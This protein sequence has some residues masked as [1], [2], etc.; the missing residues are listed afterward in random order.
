MK[1]TSIKNWL[2]LGMIFFAVMVCLVFSVDALARVG[3]GHS[4]GGG[5]S[6][7]GGRGGSSGDGGAIIWLIFQL[8]RFLVYL[9]IEYPLIGI[10]L[11]LIVVGGVVYFFA[12][13]KRTVST[14][15][16]S[17]AQAARVS[18]A[19]TSGRPEVIARSFNQLRKFDPNFSEIVFTDFCYA[20]Y[21][22]AHEA[23][24][25]GS[26]ALDLFSPYLSEEARSAL[27]QRN[28]PFLKE[29]K[30]IIV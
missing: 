12:R 8:V 3:G 22:K 1:Q 28:A 5:R 21:G 15:F 6:S 20:L 7:G 24:G 14:G 19:Q 29:V 2:R 10:P 13:S 11:D 17:Y 16:A 23:R 30:G 18:E 9:T 27:L 25:R 4:Y 26:T